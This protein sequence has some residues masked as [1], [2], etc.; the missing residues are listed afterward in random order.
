MES[1]V[2]TSNKFSAL[3]EDDVSPCAASPDGDY[4]NDDD[5]HFTASPDQSLWHSK[6]KNIDGITIIGHFSL[7][8]SSSKKKKKK[9]IAKKSKDN[10]PQANVVHPQPLND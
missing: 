6:I 3:V 4:C 2:D 5:S 10:S 7:S 1:V 9:R 8:E